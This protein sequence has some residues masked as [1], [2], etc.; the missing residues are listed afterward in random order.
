MKLTTLV[1]LATLTTAF[2][3]PDEPMVNQIV[4]ESQ[5]TSPKHFSDRIP[6]KDDVL[7][8]VGKTFKDAVA[9]SEN[10]I[11]AA[12]HAATETGKSL[13]NSFT[14][15]QSWTSWDVGNW[16][17]SAESTPALYSGMD[18]IDEYEDDHD[19]HHD[20]DED[21]DHHG[22]KGKSKKSKKSKKAKKAKKP[23][24]KP[25]GRKPHHGHKKP[26]MTV[27]ELISKSKYTTK[28]AKLINGYDDIVTQLNGTQANWTIFAPTDKA[29]DKIPKGHEPSAEVIKAILGYHVSPDFYPAGRVLVTHT[30]PTT[31][32]EDALG[33]PQRLRIGLGLRGLAVN[34]YSRVIA[35][36]IFGTNG[37][38]HGV[39]SVLLP[40][41]PAFKILTLLPGEFSTLTL[42]LE[43]TGLFEAIKSGTHVGGTFFAPNN[44]AFKR[45]GPKINAFLF[46]SYGE[47]YLKAL[48][49]Y[50]VV[51]NQTL[52]SDAFYGPKGE[53]EIGDSSIPKG[54][55]HAE[56]PTLLKG[57]SLSIDVARFGG[58]ISM[59]INGFGRVA[60]QDGLVKDGVVHIIHSILIPP[61]TPGGAAYVGGELDV[62]DLKERLG[63]FVDED[64]VHEL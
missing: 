42:G 44:M 12:I 11:D 16:L 33:G 34:F 49:K 28:L 52:Y 55:F 18:I 40:P 24:H 37:V 26:N 63:E 51:A 48:L 60:V 8:N 32:Y 62:E 38:I 3:L 9:V 19:D 1:P 45:L 6:S 27:Y 54:R 4:I 47:K 13:T 21:H 14:C 35:V 7:S 2:V 57:K 31:Y 59:K 43:K 53:G 29:F 39:D 25:C 56:L 58:L 22:K 23:H 64:E 5:K 20:R 17:E 41:P 10:A 50:H 46:S 36:N 30:I 15:H 61:K